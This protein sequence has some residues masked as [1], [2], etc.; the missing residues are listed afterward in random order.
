MNK[1]C[2]Y[3]DGCIIM[4]ACVVIRY[5]FISKYSLYFWH[6]LLC[7]LY[8]GQEFGAASEICVS[9]FCF[10]PSTTGTCY[11]HKATMGTTC[12]SGKVRTDSATNARVLVA[13]HLCSHCSLLHIHAMFTVS[14]PCCVHRFTFMSVGFDLNLVST[15]WDK[16]LLY[17]YKKF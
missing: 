10:D 5:Y 1:M 16:N 2:S 13:F 12:G 6:F 15:I 8:Q 9:M 3:W 4:Q 11:K 14:H 17:F 7:E